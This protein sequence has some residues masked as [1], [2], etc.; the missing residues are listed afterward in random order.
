LTSNQKSETNFRND[1]HSNNYSN[2]FDSDPL[3]N[4]NL[5]TLSMMNNESFKNINNKTSQNSQNSQKNSEKI[6]SSTNSTKRH[7]ETHTSNSDNQ[8]TEYLPTDYDGSYNQPTQTNI[9]S[10]QNF[11][12]INPNNTNA[13]SL[14]NAAKFINKQKPNNNNANIKLITSKREVDQEDQT[15]T[16]HKIEAKRNYNTKNFIDSSVSYINNQ[17]DYSDSKN[18]SFD[19][20]LSVKNK[21]YKNNN[22][23]MNIKKE[24]KVFRPPP[25][26]NDIN[27]NT[28]PNFN[29]ISSITQ[30]KEDFE[31]IKEESE[32]PLT[33]KIIKKLTPKIN[34]KNQTLQP[35]KPLQHL[36]FIEKN[37]YGEKILV[38][39]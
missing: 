9:E 1:T 26:S 24:K 29:D 27:N 18:S 4:E 23:N 10:K 38:T 30:K 3:D 36:K 21:I 6:G 8:V 14:N 19:T 20:T 13:N 31:V 32:Y 7:L 25:N 37:K 22:I 33:K 35:T 34:S 11:K 12:K 17:T 16:K 15:S 5:V 2:L 28:C 39:K